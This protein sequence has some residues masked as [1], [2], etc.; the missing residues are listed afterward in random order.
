MC[1]RIAALPGTLLL[2]SLACSNGGGKA[3]GGTDADTDV[4][5]D[6]DSDADTDT[7]TDECAAV[8]CNQECVRFADV[9]AAAGGDGL[10][11]GTAFQTV[12]PAIDSAAAWAAC[13]ETPC[14][15]WVARGTYYVYESSVHDTINLAD[16]VQVYGSF[17]KEE[18]DPEE[19]DIEANPTILDGRAGPESEDRV[20]H[21]VSAIPSHED[22]VFN[23]AILDGLTI[24]QGASLGDISSPDAVGAGLFWAALGKPLV[25]RCS[26]RNNESIQGAAGAAIG[27][28]P[29]SS[30]Y[31]SVIIE[32]S[33]FSWNSGLLDWNL[34]Y[35]G[36][37]M[38]TSVQHVEIRRCLFESNSADIGAAFDAT[39][40]YYSG[41]L[42][43]VENSIF[44]NNLSNYLGNLLEFLSWTTSPDS[45]V[46]IVNSVFYDN[47]SLGPPE[48]DAQLR[49]VFTV[50]IRNSIDINSSM[51]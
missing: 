49:G 12:Q 18:G 51:A 42:V 6:A 50:T 24:T 43:I 45:T 2:V 25:R 35:G 23:D 15:V 38:L 4:D 47:T 17:S 9:E 28:F 39:S 1:L 30:G 11:W 14:Q 21:V 40:G 46:E 13:C 29:G 31:L 34:S 10:S 36:A 20:Y 22:E 32:D 26:F 33:V 7:G 48:Q 27:V 16:R 41:M 44:R 8:V 5:T 19:R 37:L 3:D